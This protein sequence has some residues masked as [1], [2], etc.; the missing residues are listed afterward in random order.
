MNA[1]VDQA[2]S[3]PAPAAH[4]PSDLEIKDAHLIFES[5]WGELE[6]ELGREHMRF[7]KEIILLGGAPGAGKGTNTAFIAK[8]RG[9][10][11][12]PIVMSS[13]LNS[14]EAQALKAQGKTEDARA[15][16]RQALDAMSV[17]SALRR[18]VQIK[19]DALPGGTA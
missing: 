2:P 1:P 17:D 12:K 7:P 19:L 18:L 15:A 16:Y 4:K 3:A 6:A 14:P 8:V 11:C 10:T 9:L 13:L 5:I